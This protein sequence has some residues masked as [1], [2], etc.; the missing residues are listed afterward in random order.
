MISKIKPALFIIDFQNAFLSPGGSFARM[1]YD[2]KEYQKV[3][4][5]LKWVY[6]KAR[7]LKIPIFFSKA[8]REKSGVDLLEQTHQ[9]L[10]EARRERIEKL[11]LCIRGSWDAAV[12]DDLKPARDDFMIEKRRDSVFQDTEVALWLRSL[13]IDTIIFSGIDTAICV[14]SSLRDAFNQG[15]DVILLADATASMK[16]TFCQST[17]LEVKENFG[18]V[19]K[20]R[21]F[22]KRIKPINEKEFQLG[23]E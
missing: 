18:L 14:E 9:L 6:K 3:I 11:P 17:L 1:G 22:F 4:P 13:G 5:T 19:F 20:S 2:I 8:I 16:K 7:F 21:E 10:P 23:W 15:W 12:I